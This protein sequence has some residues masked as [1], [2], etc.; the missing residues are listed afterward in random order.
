LATAARA[1]A[2]SKPIPMSSLTVSST[3]SAPLALALEPLELAPLAPLELAPLFWRLAERSFRLKSAKRL[4]PSALAYV[5]ACR[6]RF[7]FLF[8]FVASL[9]S[10]PSA[11]KKTAQDPDAALLFLSR[12]LLL[13]GALIKLIR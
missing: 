7:S 8:F 1:A 4:E 6:R 10:I 13:L 11:A 9:L 12:L 5:R 3:G 2:S